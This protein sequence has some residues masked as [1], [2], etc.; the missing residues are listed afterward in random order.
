MVGVNC[1]YRE[2]IRSIRHKYHLTYIRY[3]L[4][5]LFPFLYISTWT[6]EGLPAEGTP[7]LKS[8]KALKVKSGD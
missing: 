3:L 5:W 6:Q 2:Q 7:K 1:S 8:A 4:G